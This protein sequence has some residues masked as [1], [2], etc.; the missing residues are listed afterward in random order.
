MPST[1]GLAA[2]GFTPVRAWMGDITK[3]KVDA[4]V[5]PSNLALDGGGGLDAMI[6]RAAGPELAFACQSLG[7]CPLGEARVTP[8]FR[9]PARWVI[10]TVGPKWRGGTYR[11]PDQLAA[12]YAS[13]LTLAQSLDI[14]RLALPAISTGVF[15]YPKPDAAKI[16]VHAVTR[17]P[18][19]QFDEI[20]LV[21]NDLETFRLYQKLL[22]Q[23]PS[24]KTT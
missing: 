1:P 12:C 14:R 2:L 4:I 5:N 23:E 20:L 11:E 21:A 17:L 3:L 8:G 10:H 19:G 22:T 18:P 6:H 16:A 7:G 9:L 15:R 24:V 13:C